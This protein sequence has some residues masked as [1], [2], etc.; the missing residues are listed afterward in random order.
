MSF[1]RWLRKQKHRCPWPIVGVL[2]VA[3]AG[4]AWGLE[5]AERK[6][7]ASEVASGEMVLSRVGGESPNQALAFDSAML[8]RIR[9]IRIGDTVRQTGL[10]HGVP[11]F[12]LMPPA[13][14]ECRFASVALFSPAPGRVQLRILPAKP[15]TGCAGVDDARWTLVT[16]VGNEAVSE[17]VAPNT[18]IVV[19]FD[20]DGRPF[21]AMRE[22]RASRLLALDLRDDVNPF[23]SWKVMGS[24]LEV[25]AN[26][27]RISR[28]TVEVPKGRRE[29]TG[30][31]ASDTS[32]LALV[33]RVHAHSYNKVLVDG[34]NELWQWRIERM[35]RFFVLLSAPL[36]ALFK[37]LEFFR[38]WC[39]DTNENKKA[40]TPQVGE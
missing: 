6:P 35:F 4:M 21:T 32:E 1:R 14:V 40:R 17:A 7:F 19:E 33:A 16:T 5:W 3:W 9:S 28:L 2:T 11:Q 30:A 13:I 29:R 38:T 39:S 12:D 20:Y 27:I 23:G 10:Q 37:I 34:D 18:P 31:A 15:E 22:L 8:T 26:P 24:Q 36:F 25:H